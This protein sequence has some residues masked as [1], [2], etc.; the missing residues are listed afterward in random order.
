MPS[1]YCVQLPY[2]TAIINN[3]VKSYVVVLGYDCKL[4]CNYCPSKNF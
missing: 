1:V 4:I 2:Q 3:G